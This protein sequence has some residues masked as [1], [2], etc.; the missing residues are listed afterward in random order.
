FTKSNLTNVNLT[1]STGLDSVEFKDA[2]LDGIILPDGYEY[3]NGYVAG[4]ERIVPWSV[5]ETKI[6]ALEEKIEELLNV[7]DPGQTQ[8]GRVSSV[9]IEA[10]PVTGELT[11]TLRL[12]ESEDLVTWDPVGDVFTRKIIL[13]EG[14]KFYR[15]SVQD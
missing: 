12:E 14:K 9:M 11:L 8:G 10:D 5:A 3:I 13:S 15:F 6:S 2:V 7:V 1:G 4:G